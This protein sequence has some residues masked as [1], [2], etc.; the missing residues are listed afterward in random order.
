MKTTSILTAV[1]TLSIA[2]AAIAAP[3]PGLFNT[4][5]D[6]DGALLAD[7]GVVDP[8]YTIIQSPDVGLP[9][10]DAVTLNSGFPVPPWLAEGPDSR[11]IAPSAASGN[12]NEGQWTYRISFDLTGFDEA[13]AEITGDW[14]VDNG[15]TAILINGSDTGN[16]NTGGFGA[17]TAFSV[18]SGFIAGVN[19]LDFVVSNAPTGANPTGLRVEILGT[20]EVPNEPANILEAPSNLTVFA[21]DP[22]TL[23]AIGDGASPLS[24]QWKKDDV[25][26]PG[27]T[28]A[29]YSMTAATQDD[30]GSYTVVVSNT[31]G[32]ATSDPPAEVLIVQQL[33]GLFPTGV[34]Q[35]GVVLADGATDPH[36]QIFVN[37]N[38]ESPDAILQDSTI[39]PIVAGPWLANDAVSKWIGPAFN[40]SAAFGGDYTYR[41]TFDLTG[42]DPTTATVGGLWASD[43]DG[44]GILV[45]GAPTGNLNTQ[46]FGGATAFQINPGSFVSR[47][48]T[49]DF[50]VNNASAGFT[51]LRVTEIS[52][53]AALGGAVGAPVIVRQPEDVMAE[54]GAQ[55]RF[56]VLADSAQ[57]LTYQWRFDGTGLDGATSPELTIFNVREERL[58]DYDVIVTNGEGTVTSEVATLAILRS[59]P[60]ILT[61]P[62]DTIA[63]RGEPATL[64]VVANGTMP[65][66]YQWRLNGTDILGA[67]TANLIIDSVGDFDSGV[68]DVVLTNSDGEFASDSATLTVLDRVPGLFSTGVD[69]SA[70][71]LL[72]NEVD[73]H[74]TFVANANG[75][76]ADTLAM[77]AIPGAWLSNSI[78]SRWIGPTTNSDGMPGLYTF[79]TTFDLLGFDLESVVVLGRWSSDNSGVE[80]RLNGVATG[81]TGSGDF[82]N[83]FD[84]EINRG[85]VAGVNTL[86]FDVNNAGDATNPVG[87]RVENLEGFGNF[88]GIPDFRITSITRP[89]G[90]PLTL[91]LTWASIPGAKYRVEFSQDLASWSEL[92]DIVDS[93]GDSTTLDDSFALNLGGR[94]F[95][96]V[97]KLP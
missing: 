83:L 97:V 60:K 24:Y 22:F 92:A 11:W 38:S 68:Y 46:G 77:G 94:V 52:G 3:I 34:D 45:N 10:P 19:T 93:Q 1:L 15:G 25:D 72:D 44:I 67:T 4:G 36:Y 2:V 59:P 71:P 88:G 70:V 37:P 89:S 56:S 76:G 69:D 66:S 75:G 12:G 87:L 61:Q 51:G 96:R 47:L 32:T 50:V 26:I 21:G 62:A 95:Y 29:R 18:T 91:T 78:T 43:N 40:T 81:I 6:G 53:G 14:A 31:F 54:L 5:V 48:N 49:I 13:S 57:P 80:V 42:F 33:G 20:V 23:S 7:S 79:Q 17:F 55:A 41:V 58:G 9:G 73:P 27:A 85:F 63:A 90:N 16:V 8:H 86:E 82:T 30:A 64:S 74:Y 65:I 35:F 28:S 39:F 84:F